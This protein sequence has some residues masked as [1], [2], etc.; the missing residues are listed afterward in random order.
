M[1]MMGVVACEE[2]SS[3]WFREL[4]VN[5]SK[6]QQGVDQLQGVGAVMMMMVQAGM[7]VVIMIMSMMKMIN[8]H[9]LCTDCNVDLIT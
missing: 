8:L 6:G 4:F 5:C 2:E 1:R 3:G 9:S 7:L